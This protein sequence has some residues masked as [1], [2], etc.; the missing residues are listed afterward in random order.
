M[1]ASVEPTETIGIV[2]TKGRS[3]KNGRGGRAPSSSQHPPISF[4]GPV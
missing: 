1:G 4:L 2:C 3:H